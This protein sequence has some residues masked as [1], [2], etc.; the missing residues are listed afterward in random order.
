MNTK[1]DTGILLASDTTIAQYLKFEK[2]MSQT[3]ISEF[4]KKRLKERYINP[5][6][7]ISDKKKKNGFLIMASSCLLIETLE[8]FYRGLGDTKHQS[9]LMFCSFFHRSGLTKDFGEYSNKFYHNVRCGILHQ[10]ETKGAWKIRRS[11][12][13]LFNRQ[14]LTINATKFQNRIAEEIDKYS[15]KL[16][17]AP[18]GDNTWFNFRKKMKT[19]IKNCKPH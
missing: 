3:K 5:L 10:G 11:G 1:P 8:S 12:D 6:G 14:T 9:E 13:E 16:A 17:N 4:I 19:I 7:E 18:W 15:D 2:E